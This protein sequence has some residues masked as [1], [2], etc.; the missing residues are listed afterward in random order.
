VKHALSH[1]HCHQ[2]TAR[3]AI[4]L[5]LKVAHLQQ[6]PIVDGIPQFITVGD[7]LCAATLP[8]NARIRMVDDSTREALQAHHLVWSARWHWVTLGDFV[9]LFN[10]GEFIGTIPAAVK[11][12]LEETSFR[13]TALYSP[14][15]CALPFLDL[16]SR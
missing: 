9:F 15:E 7:A 6:W 10:G 14:N 1:L 13:P 3:L 4:L 2:V 16:C 12:A 8:S 5:T 11:G